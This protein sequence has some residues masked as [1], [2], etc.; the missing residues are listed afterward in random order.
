MTTFYG[1][2]FDISATG[3][4]FDSIES[5]DKQRQNLTNDYGDP[6]E[7]F[8]IQFIDG[9]QIDCELA[10]VWSVNQANLEEF[11]QKVEDWEDYQK[12]L[13]II[14]VGELGYSHDQVIDHPDDLDIDIYY[15]ESLE[16]LAEE[17]VDEGLFGEIPDRFYA[18]I[19][20]E[21]IARDLSFDYCEVI[22][23]GENLVYRY[24]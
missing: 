13:Y 17:F 6:V 18:Y 7:E 1:Q 12:T 16:E 11:F 9:E 20:F 10:K 8:E 15:V 19:D 5:Y 23:G 14:A 3:F 24:V 22:I 21:A 2:P 4:Y